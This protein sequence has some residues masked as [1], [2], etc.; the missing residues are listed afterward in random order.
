ML[1]FVVKRGVQTL[2]VLFLSLTLVFFVIRLSGDPTPLFMPPEATPEQID[3]FRTI[4]GFDRPLHEQYIDFMTKA[5]RGDFGNSLKTQ[6]DALGEVL[7]RLLATFQ[8]AVTALLLSLLISIPLGILSAY[9][10][11]SWYDRVGVLFTV[12]GQ[13]I[14]NFWFGLILILIFSVS[15][16]WLPTSGG[17]SFLHLILPAVTVASY[18]IARFT[19]FTRSTM[20]DVL[21]K[22][23]IRT[24]KASGVPAA[25]VLFRYALKNTLIPIITL[26]ALDLGT[27]LGGSI[28]AETV[29]AWPGTGRLILQSL[30]ARDF[31][32][33]L[34]GVFIITCI[35][36]I[37]NF[38]VDILYA[39]VNPQI[40]L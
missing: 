2:I 1:D 26:V 32:V 29:F 3:E 38:V 20:L 14:P 16:K 35:Y 22:D 17:G 40:R 6:T 15:L 37:I 21:R 24:A 11:N 19:R 13:A 9:R 10:R 28:I 18:S 25:R 7:S 12:L 27:L 5:A 34:A 31:P 30:L 4:L 23:Y 36:C 33:V 8:L 39:Y